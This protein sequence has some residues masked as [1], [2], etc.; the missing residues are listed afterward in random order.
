MYINYNLLYSKN[1]SDIDYHVLQ[2]IFQKEEKL[3]EPFLDRFNILEELGLIQY[4][5][6]KEGQ[7]KGVRISRKGK[8]FLSQ[9]QTM[10]YTDSIGSLV[11]SLISL[12]KTNGKHVGNK[13][14]VQSRLIWF[15]AQTGFSPKVIRLT[16]EEY[17][18]DNPEYT[19]SLE[20]LIWKPA[21]IA[22]SVHKQLKGSKLYD[23]ICFKYDLNQTFLIETKK[24]KAIEWLQSVSNLNVPKG[25]GSELYFTGSY[26]GDVEQVKKIEEYYFN[27][28]SE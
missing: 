10:S 28:I 11:E 3:L 17:L 4:L 20:N 27:F 9:L 13:L 16:V 8:S 25:V 23:C 21:S 24:N 1:L 19:M 2:K 12:Y 5:K 14:E 6:G 22:F 7:A 26:Q 15:I 18:L